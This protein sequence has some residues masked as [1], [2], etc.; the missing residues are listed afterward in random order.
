MGPPNTLDGTVRTFMRSS[1]GC[2]SVP[3]ALIPKCGSLRSGPTHNACVA[4]GALPE[5]RRPKGSLIVAST[6]RFGSGDSSWGQKS[7]SSG[8]DIPVVPLNSDGPT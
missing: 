1:G 3:L 4:D 2:I 8:N 7:P 6:L 5:R